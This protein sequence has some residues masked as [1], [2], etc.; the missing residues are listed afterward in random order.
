MAEDAVVSGLARGEEH[1]GICKFWGNL[2]VRVQA[3]PKNAAYI[4]SYASSLS[5]YTG[6]I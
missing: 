6:P 4:I 3:T 1:R 2:G 5:T